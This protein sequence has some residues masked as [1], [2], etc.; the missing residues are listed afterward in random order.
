MLREHAHEQSY[1]FTGPVT[2]S[3][4][5]RDDLSTGRFRVRSAAL[6]KVTPVSDS[7]VTDTAVRRAPA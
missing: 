7:S 2:I 6:A 4:D 5:E 3:F 1:V